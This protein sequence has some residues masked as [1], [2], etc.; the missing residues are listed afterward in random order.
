MSTER[1][2]WRA[3]VR[4]IDFWLSIALFV[5]CLGGIDFGFGAGFFSSS[6]ANPK[7]PRRNQRIFCTGNSESREHVGFPG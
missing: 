4:V 2:I 5:G 6:V 7:N 1:R 3:P